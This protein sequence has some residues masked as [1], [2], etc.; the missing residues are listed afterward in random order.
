MAVILGAGPTSSI[1]ATQPL[2]LH[3]CGCGNGCAPSRSFP[4]RGT[5]QSCTI[6]Q[7]FSKNKCIL[8]LCIYL[9]FW[10]AQGWEGGGLSSGFT[11]WGEE[12]DGSPV[13]WRPVL[14]WLVLKAENSACYEAVS[15]EQVCTNSNPNCSILSLCLRF[16]R[17]ARF[18]G[19]CGKG[20]DPN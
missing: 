4:R 19:V 9:H 12:D 8:K 11:G 20:D 17:G 1:V 18:T 5:C 10:D 2:Q 16:C 7:F 14:M 13:C 3:P 15:K 6:K